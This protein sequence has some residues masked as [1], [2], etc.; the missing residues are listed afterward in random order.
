[1]TSEPG[2]EQVGRD[3]HAEQPGLVALDPDIA[4]LQ[5]ALAFPEALDLRADQRDAA[6]ER[7]ENVVVVARPSVL[8]DEFP[9]GNS[10]PGRPGLLG[11]G[12][13]RVPATFPIPCSDW[14]PSC[15]TRWSAT[16]MT[17]CPRRPAA[18][19]PGRSKAAPAPK[20][21]SATRP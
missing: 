2:G 17:V 11:H 1:M 21:W 14:R 9:P 5:D 16:A 7:L 15:T 10:G 13:L 3:V 8:G 18:C 4:V 6:L 19:W 12:L 20:R